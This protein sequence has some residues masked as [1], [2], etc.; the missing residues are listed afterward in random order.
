LVAGDFPVPDDLALGPDGR[1]YVSDIQSGTVQ[2]LEP[3]GRSTVLLSGLREP[4]G[5]VVLPGGALIVVEQGLNRLVRYD[6]STGRM[7]PF[8]SLR[9]ATGQAGIDGIALDDSLPGKP[10][11]IVPDSPNGTVLRVGL[12]DNHV[13]MIGRGFV[14]P[15]AAWVEPAGSI[16]VADG[17]GDRLQRLHVNG[18]VE[19]LARLPQPDDVIEDRAGHIYVTTL[20]DGAVHEIDKS[21]R[22]DRVLV[23]GLLLPQGL[24]LDAKGGLLV[25]DPG[26]HRIVRIQTP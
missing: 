20:S 24:A 19:T 9:N 11:L 15:V 10:A 4:E 16:L 25:T 26:H 22:A 6:P 17:F 3:G 2:W 1:V 13:Q 14:R 5:I 18:T 12:D 7:A 21:T 23:R 8:L